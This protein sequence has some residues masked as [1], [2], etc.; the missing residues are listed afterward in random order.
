M[1][2]DI[3][4]LLPTSPNYF[5]HGEKSHSFNNNL[6]SCRLALRLHPDLR[7]LL[8][9]RWSLCSHLTYFL[10]LRAFSPKM[11]AKKSQFEQ[12]PQLWLK[13]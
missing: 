2:T 11:E 12:E 7:L 6:L 5:F 10:L 9:L 3:L 1:R 13:F 4:C 8:P